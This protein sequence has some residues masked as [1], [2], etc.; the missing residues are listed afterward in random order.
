M[1]DRRVRS[2]AFSHI[3]PSSSLGKHPALTQDTLANIDIKDLDDHLF[4]EVLERWNSLAMPKGALAALGTYTA[5]IAAI[6]QTTEPSLSRGKALVFVGRHGIA[7]SGLVTPYPS[8]VT[9]AMLSTYRQ[10]DAV[11]CSLAR[12]HGMAFEAVPVMIERHTADLRFEAAMSTDNCLRSVRLGQS[13]ALAAADDRSSFLCI[14]EMGIG[15]TTS[16]ACLTAW[17]TGKTPD[18]VVGLGSGLAPKA[19]PQKVEVVDQALRRFS[20]ELKASQQGHG[21]NSRSTALSALSHLGGFE[22]AAM[23]GCMLQAAQRRM[24]IV[25]DGFIA[26]AA[27]LIATKIQPSCR[28]YLIAATQSSEPGHAAA[29]EQLNLNHK[30]VLDHG[31]RLGEGSAALLAVPILRSGCSILKHTATLT[32]VLQRQTGDS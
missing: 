1:F 17:C 28:H 12:E 15:N 25:L 23:V 27:A 26:T 29:L 8:S 22:I 18:Q 24:V 3:R 2:S 4:S 21:L 20:R 5:Q 16:A 14:G 30:P 11:A 19:R 13:H 9:E 31:L 10:G 7:T 6:Q 32:T